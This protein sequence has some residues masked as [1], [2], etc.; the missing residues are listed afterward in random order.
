MRT[1]DTPR[2]P[3]APG[4]SADAPRA[5]VFA[6]AEPDHTP[7]DGPTRLRYGVDEDGRGW[8][9]ATTRLRPRE[10]VAA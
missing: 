7:D 2:S 1:S 4:Y 9:Q 3:R 8:V 6:L 5:S 10:R